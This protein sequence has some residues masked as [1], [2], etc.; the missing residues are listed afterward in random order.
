[1]P[2]GA[3]EIACPDKRQGAFVRALFEDAPSGVRDKFKAL[4]NELLP[5]EKQLCF[6]YA[7][8]FKMWE[9]MAS[10]GEAGR[11][12]RAEL[13]TLFG[14]HVGQL[15]RLALEKKEGKT[16][17]CAGTMLANMASS[18][19][20][21]N[22]K[23]SETNSAYLT[24]TK[25][26]HNEK[27]LVQVL[28]P[29]PISEAVQQ[30]LKTA[31]RYRKRLLLLK[32]AFGKEWKEAARREGIPEAYWVFAELANL[33]EKSELQWWKSL[34]PLIKKNKPDLL[35]KLQERSNRAKRSI[36]GEPPTKINHPWSKYANEFHNVL[37]T[38]AGYR[39]RG[40]LTA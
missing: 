7:W 12:A 26:I 35:Q 20:K 19:G 22:K 23:L 31:E 38:I 11:E 10:D 21:H 28:F 24:E 14:T 36:P 2:A 4:F 25:K 8:F 27:Q 9:R 1:M 30:E 34:W 6:I 33:S 15:L 32:A 3:P 17:Q 13:Q 16:K 18:V 37:R 39:D 40:T 29:K 5:Y